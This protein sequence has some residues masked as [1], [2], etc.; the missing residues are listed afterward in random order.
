VRELADGRVYSG[1]QAQSLGLVDELGDLDRA[2]E[3]S[4]D[5]A[6]LEEATVVRYQPRSPG[7]AE[8]L[9]SRLTSAK[10]EA[11]ALKVLRT[12]GLSPTPELQYLYRP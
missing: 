7:L 3:I 1:L 2:A 9:S 11:E 5:L 10:P 8:L 4:E 12:A 6:G